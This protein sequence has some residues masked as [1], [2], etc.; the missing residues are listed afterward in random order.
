[1]NEIE[2]AGFWSR[3]GAALIDSIFWIIFI[4]IPLSLIYGEEYWTG[5]QFYYGIW[6]LILSYIFPFVATV[7][8]WLKFF[9]TPGKM[10]LK[11][12]IVDAKTGNKLSVGR[13][14]GR[15]FAYIPAMLPLFLGIIWVGID[16]KK[17]GWHDKIA[18]IVVIKNNQSE[19]VIF[20]NQ[21]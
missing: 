8:F 11:L 7:W 18:G 6:D 19:P 17:Q 4:I 5:E 1:M 13:A 21:V 2:Y 14:I 9:G 10:A 12:K 15:Y 20:E 16:K 3:T